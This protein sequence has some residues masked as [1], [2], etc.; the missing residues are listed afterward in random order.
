[1][2]MNVAFQHLD[3]TAIAIAVDHAAISKGSVF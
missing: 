1:M 3:T 2:L